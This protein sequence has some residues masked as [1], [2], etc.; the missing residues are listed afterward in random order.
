MSNNKFKLTSEL[1]LKEM[2]L[3]GRQFDIPK[4]V[5]VDFSKARPRYQYKDNKQTDVVEAY[6]LGAI[7]D[8]TAQA[9]EQGLID[10]DMVKSIRLEVLGGLDDLETAIEQEQVA[11]VEL[12][13]TK[14]MAQWVAQGSRGGFR[15]LKLVASG[16]KWLV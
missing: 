13:D 2:A 6:I 8:K 4:K 1:S 16:L 9:I 11:Y 15:E 3:D 12:L 7:D 10:I 5:L 14:V